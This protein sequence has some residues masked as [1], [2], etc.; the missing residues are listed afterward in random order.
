LRSEPEI[1]AEQS[2]L[3]VQ[4]AW[5][6]ELALAEL[7]LAELALAELALAQSAARLAQA[8]QAGFCALNGAASHHQEVQTLNWRWMDGFV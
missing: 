8:E 6:A 4:A 7:A 2:Q 1:S 5:L 3:A